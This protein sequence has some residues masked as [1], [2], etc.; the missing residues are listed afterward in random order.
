MTV[1]IDGVPV[2]VAGYSASTATLDTDGLSDNGIAEGHL[3]PRAR[4]T[5]PNRPSATP[6]ARP[7]TLARRAPARRRIPATRSIASVRGQPAGRDPRVVVEKQ[8]EFAGRTRTPVLRECDGPS[9]S[10]RTTRSGN[11][12][13]LISS[14]SAASVPS[15]ELVVHRDHLEPRAVAFKRRERIEAAAAAMRHG[16]ASGR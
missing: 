2:S 15:R 7:G 3:R 6:A 12:P 8:D 14:A 13:R 5:P 4:G 9:C 1:Y 10:S 16:R 11:R